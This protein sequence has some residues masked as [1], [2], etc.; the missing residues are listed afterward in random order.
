ML[1]DKYIEQ[2]F[3]KLVFMESCLIVS[4][5]WQAETMAKTMDLVGEN[6]IFES[7]SIKLAFFNKLKAYHPDIKIINCDSSKSRLLKDISYYKDC[8]IVFDKVNY[9]TDFDIFN[10]INSM[11]RILI[12]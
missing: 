8:V 4:D 7:T 9:C 6:L 5:I 3:V 11:D 12:C 10:M 1:L 2:D